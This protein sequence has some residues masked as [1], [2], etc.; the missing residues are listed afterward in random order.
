MV[1]FVNYDPRTLPT[2]VAAA[3]RQLYPLLDFFSNACRWPGVRTEVSNLF[4]F[5]VKFTLW[6]GRSVEF[7][8]NP[9]TQSIGPPPIYPAE[10][11]WLD[12]WDK[13]ITLDHI[14]SL[15]AELEEL[16]PLVKLTSS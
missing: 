1:P 14:S 13:E 8:F 7:V 16:R 2:D 4:P 10:V 6:D 5:R 12:G 15:I 9:I 3:I 11:R